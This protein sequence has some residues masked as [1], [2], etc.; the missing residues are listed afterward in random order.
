MQE[1]LGVHVEFHNIKKKK[2]QSASTGVEFFG[3]SIQLMNIILE[4]L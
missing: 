4:G 3:S 1:K 2:H